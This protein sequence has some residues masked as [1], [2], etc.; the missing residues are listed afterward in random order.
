MCIALGLVLHLVYTCV[1]K[2]RVADISVKIK[3]IDNVHKTLA[4][5]SPKVS[6]GVTSVTVQKKFP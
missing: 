4:L 5:R 1:S 6:L 2:R 3:F